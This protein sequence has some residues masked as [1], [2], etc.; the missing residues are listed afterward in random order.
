MRSIAE[1][2]V[3]AIVGGIVGGGIVLVAGALDSDEGPTSQTSLETDAASVV[4]P[5]RTTVPNEPDPE[6]EQLAF[7]DATL[8]QFNPVPPYSC[9]R[10]AAVEADITVDGTGYL[11]YYAGRDLVVR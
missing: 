1:R 6:S 8:R 10:T 7:V 11:K 4:S 2:L 3:I 9:P 5:T